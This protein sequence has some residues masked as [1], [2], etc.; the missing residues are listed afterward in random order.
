MASE[1]YPEDSVLF[2]EIYEDYI[3]NKNSGNPYFSFNVTIESHGPYDT[4]S[5]SGS[6]EYLKG[7]YSKSC[8]NAMNNYLSVIHQSDIEL[9]KLF[10]KLRIDSEPVILLTFGDHLPWMGNDNEFYEEMGLNIDTNTDEGFRTYYS[11]HYLI[12]ANNVA[13]KLF[14]NYLYLKQYWQN[15][16]L[17]SSTK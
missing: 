7:D 9:E 16:F 10:E 11:T 6:K 15:E 8:K 1:H 14:Q 3:A 13:K 4:E 2:S 12:W 5:Y 17:F